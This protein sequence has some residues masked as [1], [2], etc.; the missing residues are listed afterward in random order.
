MW[1]ATRSGSGSTAT[2]CADVRDPCDR[3]CTAGTSDWKAD[4]WVHI[5]AVW[6]CDKGLLLWVNGQKKAERETTRRPEGLAPLLIGTGNAPCEGRA[7]GGALDE[8]KVF[9]RPLTAEEIQAD[10]A[11]ALALTPAPAATPEQLAAAR[12]APPVRE[13]EPLENL[14]HLTFDDGFAAAAARAAKE[15]PTRTGRPWFRA[16]RARPHSSG[17]RQALRY[18]EEQNLR[19]ECGAIA[20]WVQLPCDGSDVKE[21][22]HLFRED[23][24][25]KVGENALWLWFYPSTACA[26]TRATGRTATSFWDRRSPGR[27]ASGTT[28]SPAGTRGAA[29]P[30]I[31]T[32]SC[33]P[34]AV[35]ATAARSSFPSPGIPSP[36][37]PLSSARKARPASA[38]GKG[39]STSS[40]SSAGR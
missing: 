9:D 2:P 23:G 24:P 14:F 21:W 1:A 37:R 12:K 19:K 16:S 22:L 26:G 28:S 4:Q 40:R 17:L 6:D 18:P 7:A 29:P 36:T 30:S 25:N 15:R 38:R 10:F 32:V 3:Y 31:S 8:L 33:A 27:K 13:R 5:A 11:G 34:S 39:P 35:P 20:A